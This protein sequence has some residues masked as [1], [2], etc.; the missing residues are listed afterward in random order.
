MFSLSCLEFLGVLLS[1]PIKA[2][3]YLHPP[4]PPPKKKKHH[5]CIFWY[6]K[7]KISHFGSKRSRNHQ[8]CERFGYYILIFLHEGIIQEVK[9]MTVMYLYNAMVKYSCT[10]LYS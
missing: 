10:I 5:L 8:G 4:P 1:K 6:S 9:F 7:V 3:K 2:A